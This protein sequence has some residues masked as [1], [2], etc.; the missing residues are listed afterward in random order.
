MNHNPRLTPEEAKN[1]T[2][3]CLLE[4]WDFFRLG[5]KP[6]YLLIH[7]FERKGFKALHGFWQNAAL[8]SPE[9][10]EAM[11]KQFTP[12]SEFPKR[13]L[14]WNGSEE[15]ELGIILSDLGEKAIDRY[16][17]VAEGDEI[18][19]QNG[20]VFNWTY[21]S[22]AKPIPEPDQ[23][24]QEIAELEKRIAELKAKQQTK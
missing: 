2:F 22:H 11:R 16:I 3:P 24:A 14:V 17:V 12:A 23:I 19:W 18:K 21:Y 10:T 9:I 6:I 4:V 15:P 7:G 8:P 5:N 1:L 13:M 20:E